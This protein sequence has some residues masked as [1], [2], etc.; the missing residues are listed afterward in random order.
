M[1]SLPK[2]LLMGGFLAG[3]P[4]LWG[5]GSV[6]GPSQPF[7]LDDF[8][9]GYAFAYTPVVGGALLVPWVLLPVIQKQAQRLTKVMIAVLASLLLNHRE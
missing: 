5:L 7:R 2:R 4:V 3:Y 6:V 8:L 9:V 1:L